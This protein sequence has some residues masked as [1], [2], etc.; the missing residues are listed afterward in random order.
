METVKIKDEQYNTM[1][2]AMMNQFKE[3][4]AKNPEP[5]KVKDKLLELK[6]AADQT[7]F[8][9]G[10][11]REGIYA[12]CDNYINGTYGVDAKKDAYKQNGADA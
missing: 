6:A 3:I 4:T 2:V 12:R 11:Q 5:D 9:T 7:P 10:R 1:W 8:L